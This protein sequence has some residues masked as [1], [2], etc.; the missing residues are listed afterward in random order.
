MNL[1]QLK[2]SQVV[3]I[4]YIELH[5]HCFVHN[6]YF[7]VIIF[8]YFQIWSSLCWSWLPFPLAHPAFCIWTVNG[9]QSKIAVVQ[10]IYKLMCVLYCLPTAVSIGTMLG[11]SHRFNFWYRE[12][13]CL[14]LHPHYLLDALNLLSDVVIGAISS[15]KA[16]GTQSWRLL[17]TEKLKTHRTVPT[18]LLFSLH[19]TW[20]RTA[21]I[22]P[23]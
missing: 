3:N 16:S 22:V 2:W 10:N 15:S 13:F 20:L 17:F 5:V 11:D 8:I 19:V 6:I 21:R 4:I 23:I 1:R 7:Y 12:L 18:L 9:G 14:L